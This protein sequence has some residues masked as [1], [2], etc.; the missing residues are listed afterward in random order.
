MN[1]F[2]VHRLPKCHRW[3]S[4]PHYPDSETG[5]SCQIGLPWQTVQ[6]KLQESNLPSRLRS[7]LV[8]ETSP[9]ANGV[10][11]SGREVRSEKRVAGR[12][13]VCIDSLLTSRFS[14]LSSRS[15]LKSTSGI[16]PA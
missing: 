13:C 3:D 6:R 12:K 2:T 11:A 7:S 5:A 15:F 8:F 9:R 16:E 1:Q 14:L 10:R 4:N